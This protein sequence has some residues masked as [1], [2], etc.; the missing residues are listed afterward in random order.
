[1]FNDYPVCCFLVRLISVTVFFQHGSLG[2][3]APFIP[4]GRVLILVAII[5]VTDYR[6]FR[7]LSSISGTIA[8]QTHIVTQSGYQD[9]ANVVFRSSSIVIVNPFYPPFV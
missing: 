6:G 3:K 2:E 1:V 7:R 4:S 9:S 5:V 8:Y